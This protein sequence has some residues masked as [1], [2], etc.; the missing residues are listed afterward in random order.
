MRCMQD[1]AIRHDQPMTK[2]LV[3][4]VCRSQNREPAVEIPAGSSTI[5]RLPSLDKTP[6]SESALSSADSCPSDPSR[7]CTGGCTTSV[8]ISITTQ[9][10]L[11]ALMRLRVLAM[12]PVME[13]EAAPQGLDHGWNLPPCPGGGQAQSTR[14][15]TRQ[16]PC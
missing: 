1:E 5:G 14:W 4:S 10:D 8:P 15:L 16:R 6:G 12:L 3:R 11:I 7:S 13:A 2:V 9:A